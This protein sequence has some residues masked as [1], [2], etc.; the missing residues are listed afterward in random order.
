[1]SNFFNKDVLIAAVVSFLFCVTF[2]TIVKGTKKDNERREKYHEVSVLISGLADQETDPIRKEAL[3]QA[4][5]NIN[6]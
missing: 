3:E 5:Y 2:L 1:M 6:R 4:S